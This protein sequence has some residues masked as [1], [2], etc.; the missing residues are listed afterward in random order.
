M[1]KIILREV[2]FTSHLSDS[3]LLDILLKRFPFHV[4]DVLF[5]GSTRS[6]RTGSP[7]V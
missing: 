7:S 1:K 3:S 4:T 2:R 5:T 6:G